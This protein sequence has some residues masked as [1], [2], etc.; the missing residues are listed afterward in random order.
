MTSRALEQQVVSAVVKCKCGKSYTRG[1]FA[2]LARGEDSGFNRRV[3]GC[4]LVLQKVLT[5]TLDEITNAF[6]KA[7]QENE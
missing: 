6:S 3:C 1:E 5:V 4:G 2:A 7:M